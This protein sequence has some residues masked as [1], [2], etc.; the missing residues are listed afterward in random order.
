MLPVP[1]NPNRDPRALID[2]IENGNLADV[3]KLLPSADHLENFQTKDEKTGDSLI[4][5]AVRSGKNDILE[6]LLKERR[7]N[8]NL[9]NSNKDNPLHLAIENND[10]KAVEILLEAGA[11]F[12]VHGKHG[13]TPL[14]LA[15]RNDNYEISEIL[16]D[17]KADLDSRNGAENTP[18]HLAAL[19]KSR[20]PDSK[21]YDLLLN[22]E[23]KDLPNK[24]GDTPSSI[25]QNG[26]DKEF[27]NVSKAKEG[28]GVK[29]CGS[30]S[31]S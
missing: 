8:P 22:K 14:H 30:R 16:I 24:N 27:V 23:A 19:N 29:R 10:I 5:F 31:S 18:F 11:A 3:Q 13:N 4:H 25:K 2:A 15:V 7:L 28:G 6:F 12:W 21:I 26:V 20:F 1:S 9:T 17:Q